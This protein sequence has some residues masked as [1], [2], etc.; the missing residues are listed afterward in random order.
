LVDLNKG[1]SLLDLIAI[2]QELEDILDCD[3]D[4]VT[5]ASLSPFLKEEILRSARPL[6]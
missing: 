1:Q 4:V 6:K 5:E 3:V 2:K